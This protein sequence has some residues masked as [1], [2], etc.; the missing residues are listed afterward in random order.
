[1]RNRLLRF[2]AVMALSLTSAAG[3]TISFDDTVATTFSPNTLSF[4]LPL[5]DPSLGPLTGVTIEFMADLDGSFSAENLSNTPGNI[6]GTLE[7]TFTLDGP[8]PLAMPVLT[9]NPNAAFGPIA[10]PANTQ[11]MFDVLDVMAADSYSTG[12]PAELAPFIGVGNIN[13]AGTAAAMASAGGD[14]NPLIFIS[15]LSGEATVRITYEYRDQVPDIPEP[16]SMYLLG[17]GLFALS[18]FRPR[19]RAKS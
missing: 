5:F 10:V 8:A 12:I 17:G 16:M 13:L 11:I 4:T 15:N 7:G 6:S 19:N 18:F 3:A 2:A 1:M 9:L 14:V